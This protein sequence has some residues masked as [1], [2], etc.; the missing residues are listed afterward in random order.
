MTLVCS[1]CGSGNIVDDMD[2][3]NRLTYKKCL[4][5]GSTAIKENIVPACATDVTDR[6]PIKEVKKMPKDIQITP[7]ADVCKR[8]DALRDCIGIKNVEFVKKIGISRSQWD[9]IRNPKSMGKAVFERIAKNLGV[10]YDWLM[11]GDGGKQLNEGK[12]IDS[13]QSTEDEINMVGNNSRIIEDIKPIKDKYA[14]HTKC[15]V[16]GCDKFRA[17][18]QYCV[19]HYNEITPKVVKEPEQPAIKAVKVL[20]MYELKENGRLATIGIKDGKYQHVYVE[21]IDKC[22]WSYDDVMFLYKATGEVLRLVQG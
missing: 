17:K 10:T 9:S 20:E 18:G 22:K 16:V 3:G 11:D 14:K 1:K 8:L 12:T 2:Y 13:K 7:S 15:L 21:G 5:C 19:K 4:M 6:K